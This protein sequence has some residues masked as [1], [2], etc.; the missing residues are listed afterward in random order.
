MI[1]SRCLRAQSYRSRL[2]RMIVSLVSV[3]YLRPVCARA[4]TAKWRIRMKIGTIRR[5]GKAAPRRGRSVIVEGIFA[6][7]VNGLRGSVGRTGGIRWQ[8]RPGSG[9]VRRKFASFRVALTGKPVSKRPS[10]S[11]TQA[12]QPLGGSVQPW[13]RPETVKASDVLPEILPAHSAASPLKPIPSL[14]RVEAPRAMSHGLPLA[15]L[16]KMPNLP[17]KR[18]PSTEARRAN[19]LR[20]I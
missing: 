15:S 8:P 6:K 2:L 19:S 7:A 1:L 5:N 11:K 10:L 16:P 9:S 3:K 17:W 20:T 13:G 4:G 14:W 18:I 12:R